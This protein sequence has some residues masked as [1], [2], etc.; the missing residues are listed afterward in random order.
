MSANQMTEQPNPQILFDTITAYQRSAALRAGIDLDIFTAI[1]EGTNTAAALAEKRQ[2]SEKGMRILCDYLTVL[3][4]LTKAENRYS[5][6]LDSSVFLNQHSPAYA[7]TIAYFLQSATLQEAFADVAAAVRKGGTA[8]SEDGTMAP[9]HPVWVEFARAMA[10][11]MAMPAELIGNL[12][13]VEKMESCKVL[14]IASGHGMFGIALARQNPRAE[15]VAVDWA[16][17][18]DVANE[19]AEKAG[20]ADRFKTLPGSAFDVEFGDGYD[21]VLLTNFLHHFDTATNET[22]LKKVHA[23]LKPGGRAVTFEF[24][25]NDDRVSPPGS[26]MFA[27]IMLATTTQG[28]AY[29]FAE[30]Q[31]MFANAGYTASEFHPLPPTIQ[32]VVIATK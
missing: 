24:I 32:Q 17:V 7:G 3:G 1:A 13:Q 27:M 26:A 30:Y 15:I 11:M 10:P 22:L 14:D 23:A 5:L 28:D 31:R 20:V 16:N 9:D 2:T 6:T 18:L 12:I 21:V 19:N 4:F 25:P 8:A 29:T